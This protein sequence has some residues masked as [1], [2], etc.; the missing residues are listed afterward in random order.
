MGNEARSRRAYIR[1]RDIVRSL[2]ADRPV[3]YAENHFRRAVRRRTIGVPDV[4]GCNYELDRL[5][6]GCRACRLHSVVVSECSNYPHAVRGET[7]AELRQIRTI[8][9]DLKRIEREPFVAGF[10]LWS[11]N[12]YATLRKRRYR[13]YSGIVDG[14]RLPK[15]S[16][17]YLRAKYSKEPFLRIFGDWSSVTEGSPDYGRTISCGELPGKCAEKDRGMTDQRTVHVFTTCESVALSLNGKEVC[18]LSGGYHLVGK[19]KFE[20]GEL[21]AVGRN[22]DCRVEDRLASYGAAR[23]IEVCPEKTEGNAQEKEAMSFLVRILDAKGNLASSWEGAVNVRVEG[24]AVLK[25]YSPDHVVETANGVGRGFVSG[26]G[27]TGSAWIVAS[28]ENLHT[29]RGEIRFG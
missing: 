17:S 24:A 18:R 3:I 20:P 7:A 19:V 25:A 10:A 28:F 16:A 29:G 5:D 27:E 6:D 12:D 26:T 21:L 9:E 4:W 14:W 13:R 8:E 1:L 15:M 23:S 11:F 22:G 2:D